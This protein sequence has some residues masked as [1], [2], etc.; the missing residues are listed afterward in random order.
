MKWRKA[1]IAYRAYERLIMR[2]LFAVVVAVHM[3]SALS[4][5][6]LAAPNGLA[7]LMELRLLSNPAVFSLSQYLLWIAHAL[8]VLRIA[9]DIVLP[10]MT[11]LSVAVGSLQ[12]SHGAI[13][14][15]LQVV[16]LVLL[17]QT[18]SHFYSRFRKANGKT[19]ARPSAED[20]LI[21]WSQQAIAATYLASGLTKLINTGG[22][23]F[24]QSPLVGVQIIKTTEQ[25]YYNTL[26]AHGYGSG[27]AIA[28]W[29][30]QHSVLVGIVM[31]AGLLLELATPLLLLGRSWA[32]LFGL[33]LLLF[34]ESV[35]RVMEL[36]FFYNECLIWIYLVNVPFWLWVAVRRLRASTAKEIHHTT[37]ARVHD[38]IR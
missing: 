15:H 25:N 27:L 7:H 2:V 24:L 26:D 29:I 4:S 34:H 31:S 28:A 6:Q 18:T 3:P 38:E 13:G 21:S 17:A 14:H 9:W 32:L 35:G 1:D 5:D 36:K 33:A 8:Y 12:N 37:T 30:V 19:V 23:W 16:S 10:Y 20:R 22:K 11:L